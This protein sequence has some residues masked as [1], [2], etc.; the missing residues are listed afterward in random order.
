MQGAPMP[1]GEADRPAGAA[2]EGAGAGTDERHRPCRRCGALLPAHYLT[3][4]LLRLPGTPE[5]AQ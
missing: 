3:C 2:R 1:G 4:P 5:P